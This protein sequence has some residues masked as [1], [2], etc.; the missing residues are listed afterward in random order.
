MG[1]DTAP[2]KYG[3]KRKYLKD[4]FWEKPNSANSYIPEQLGV[5]AIH[6]LVSALTSFYKAENCA[7]KIWCDN[8]GTVN[9]SRKRKR[10]VLRD[11]RNIRKKQR[12]QSST[13]M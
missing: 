3:E 10:R 5:C 9:M 4:N 13:T 12:P 8:M 1:C 11:I 6:H 7:T 2:L